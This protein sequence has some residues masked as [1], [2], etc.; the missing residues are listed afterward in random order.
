MSTNS[1]SSSITAPEE[2]RSIE[3]RLQTLEAEVQFLRFVVFAILGMLFLAVIA[4]FV[5]AVQL[6]VFL[7]LFAAIV[8]FV[9]TAIIRSVQFLLNRTVGPPL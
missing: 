7:T 6:V 9:V 4:Y 8:I 3:S 5:P 2:N 1:S